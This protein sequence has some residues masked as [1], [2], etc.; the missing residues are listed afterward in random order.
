MSR[1][2]SAASRTVE[3]FPPA[4]SRQLEMTWP[5]RPAPAAPAPSSRSSSAA[6][7][8]CGHWARQHEGGSGA[9]GH[10]RGSTFCSC[11]RFTPLSGAAP[12]RGSRLTDIVA[13]KLPAGDLPKGVVRCGKQCSKCHEP[14]SHGD[15]VVVRGKKHLCMPCAMKSGSAAGRVLRYI[16]QGHCGP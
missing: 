16:G 1:K 2:P 4:A 3:M 14:F 8:T 12:R 11:Q 9:C 15:A 13:S 10:L 6:R 5:A 7:C